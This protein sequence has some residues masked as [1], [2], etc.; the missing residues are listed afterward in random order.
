MTKQIILDKKKTEPF[1][2]AFLLCYYL[3]LFIIDMEDF[4][5]PT[6]PTIATHTILL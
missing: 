4:F 5:I 6:I 1:D 3:M 2:S